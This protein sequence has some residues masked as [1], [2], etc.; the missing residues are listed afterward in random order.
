MRADLDNREHERLLGIRNAWE[1]FLVKKLFF[2]TEL[3]SESDVTF[4]CKSLKS[5]KKA[6]S[7]FDV[8][9]HPEYGSDIT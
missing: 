2:S 5:S 7:D 8:V 3:Q 1:N 9:L 6:T 4:L